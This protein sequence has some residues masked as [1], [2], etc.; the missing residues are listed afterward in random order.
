MSGKL[1]DFCIG[2]PPYQ[3]SR[4]TTKDM[5]VYHTFMDAAY[6]VANKVELITPA[7]FLFNSGATPKKW[8]EERLKDN[9]FKVLHYEGNS[10]KVF[11]NTSIPG[12]VVISY[13]DD[14]CDYGPIEIFS[15][16][17]EMNSIRNKIIS[18]EN[19]KGLDT[20]MYPYSAYTLSEA[21]WNDH[22]ERRAR[23]EYIIKNRN[24]LSKEEK[25]GELSN[26][27]I[28]T[29]N[30]FD[31]LPELFFDS[32]PNDGKD[33]CAIVGRRNGTRC[34]KY[35]L[36]K[37]INVADNYKYYKVLIS[38]GDGA[39]GQIG[40]PIPARITGQP[41][42]IEPNTGY[43]QT[44]Q[45]IGSVKTIKEADNIAKYIKT[46]FARTAVG[47]LKITQHY[48][49]DKWKYVPLQDFTSSSDIDWTKSV[50]EIDLQLYSK[51]GLSVE[52]INFIETHVKEMV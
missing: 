1:F 16:F 15:A 17:P 47:I 6:L 10:S 25:K 45:S 42:V 24:K 19:H 22:P 38:I 41:L 32:K 23:V 30:I 28:I 29:T 27:R 37:Y 8:N 48:P 50:H 13:R 51:Y 4:E 46:K 31:L 39:A 49:V 36:Q 18:M 52:E 33:Y 3:E 14:S 34:T 21:F 2:N 43:T 44:F 40:N 20:I 12:G 35:I 26:F 11:S 7:K 5:P 9:H